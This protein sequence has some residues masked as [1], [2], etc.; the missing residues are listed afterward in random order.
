MTKEVSIMTSDE[1]RES[2]LQLLKTSGSCIKGIE[3]AANF[4]VSRQVI[5]QD[6]AV[7]RASGAAIIATLNGYFMPPEKESSLL[8][9]TIV[10]RHMGEEAIEDELVTIVDN[11]GRVVDVIVEHPVYGEIKGNLMVS[12]RYDVEQF[13]KM[14]REKNAEPLSALTDGIHL[15]TLEVPDEVT[16]QRI[17]S[18]LRNK[19]YLIETS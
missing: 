19:N 7:L 15:H 18:E 10:T 12:T 6:I 1:R 8:R 13:M 14:V 5:V 9:K 11:G 4:N 3:L 17:L 2:I 16:F